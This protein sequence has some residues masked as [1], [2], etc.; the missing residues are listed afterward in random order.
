MKF[1]MAYSK[2]LSMKHLL[3]LFFFICLVGSTTAS[4][5]SPVQQK[6]EEPVFGGQVH[7]LEFGKSNPEI[8]L[9]LHGLGNDA[10][11]VWDD[12][13]PEL[14]LKYHVVVPDLPGFGRSSKGNHLY[15]PH[16]YATFLNWLVKTLPEKPVSLVGH[17]LGGGIALVYAARYG[18]NLK[19]LV[20][21]DSVGLLHHLAV[22][23][24]FVRQQLNIDLPFF[25]SSI[26]SSLERAANLLLEKASFLRLDPD[27][28]LSSESMRDKFLDGDP[29]KIAGL[30]LVQT[31]YSLI[32]GKVATPTW[33]LWGENDQIAPLRIGKILSWNLPEARLKIL[34][35]IGH[36]P[37][38]E[39][40]STFLP[41]LLQALSQKPKKSQPVQVK[42]EAD[43][44]ICKN[45]EDRIFEGAYTSLRIEHCK[46]VMIKNISTRKL[47]ILDSEVEIELSSILGKDMD[48]AIHVQRSRLAMTG[49]DIHAGTAIV[50][51]QSRLDLAG[52]RFFGSE[53]AIKGE[54]N[55]SSI[56][57][58]TSV[59]YL[60]DSAISLNLSQSLTAGESL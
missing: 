24:N 10:G 28:I 21:V 19:K 59:K 1:S 29:V 9:L 34:S 58:S 44:G 47:E 16:A 23:Q 36:S 20:L 56:L 46:N 40:P 22:S 39:K 2:L 45:E 42:P 15:S 35:G 8:L 30:S 37:M 14:S 17:S 13:L 18:T 38:L 60:K 48:P 43:I 54:G 27:R 31:D 6:F 50:T 12:L 57:C 52:V 55:R 4:P 41:I 3:A 11:K 32:L 53:E 7:V 5:V 25:S 51:N 33:L 26:E 49:V